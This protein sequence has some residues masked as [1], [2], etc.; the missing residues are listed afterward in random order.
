MG[1]WTLR[2]GAFLFTATSLFF[3]KYINNKRMHTHRHPKQKQYVYLLYTLNGNKHIFWSLIYNVYSAQNALMLLSL[4]LAEA[5]CIQNRYDNY[6]P[7]QHILVAQ[8]IVRTTDSCY[9]DSKYKNKWLCLAK[10]FLDSGYPTTVGLENTFS[11]FTAS[12]V[13]QHSRPTILYTTIRKVAVHRPICVLSVLITFSSHDLTT[14]GMK[15]PR[16]QLRLV[17]SFLRRRYSFSVHK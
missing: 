4:R 15:W 7:F 11:E 8:P 3:C 9:T 2:T 17:Y 10:L 12:I 14:V 5:T 1:T 16:G 6:S 13:L